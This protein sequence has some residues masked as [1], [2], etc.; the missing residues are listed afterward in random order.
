MAKREL[1]APSEISAQWLDDFAHRE[2]EVTVEA[3]GK[4]VILGR[5]T[6]KLVGPGLP[7]GTRLLV[8]VE[9]TIRAVTPE[10]RER[11]HEEGQEAAERRQEKRKN[12]LE[13]DRVEALAQ[14]RSYT[15]PFRYDM[16]LRVIMS[17][18]RGHSM[19]NVPSKNSVV[20][21]R[22]KEE[23]RD[24]VFHRRSGQLLC[25]ALGPHSRAYGSLIEAYSFYGNGI[26]ARI[27]CKICLKIA[28][29][30]KTGQ[31]SEPGGKV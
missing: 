31:S 30:W 23:F 1:T 4:S 20:H 27:T 18:L 17:G 21:I 8:T 5:Q 25:S 19:G 2:V 10:E 29:R 9:E 16:A 24:G 7:P 12:A 6:L 13:A 22:L 15:F 14:H 3:D 26:P 11:E 28:E